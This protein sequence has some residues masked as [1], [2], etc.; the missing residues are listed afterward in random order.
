MKN[1]FRVFLIVFLVATNVF[2]QKTLP[3]KNA[4][5]S[6]D[7]RAKDLVKRM[8]LDEKIGQMTQI[9]SSELNDSKPGDD[10][11][12][13]FRPYLDPAKAEKLVKEYHV[14]SFLV[15]FAVEPA[16]WV[17]FTSELQTIAI[18][19]SRWG[20]P[21]IYGNDNIHGANYVVG[22]TIFPQALGLSCTF[23]TTLAK[24]MGRVTAVE[25]ADLGQP[26]NFAPV[27]DLGRNP[28]WPR[29]YESMGEST[30]LISKMGVAYIKAMQECN[31][32]SPY[33]I[34]ATAKHFIGYGD[35]KSGWDRMPAIISDQEL[36]EY[37]VPP[38]REAIKAGVKTFMINSAEVN[39]VPV[40]ASARLINGLLRK[41]LGFDGVVVTD[42]ADI[43]QLIG[44][45][46][47]AKDER[48][49]T[50]MALLAGIDMSMTATSTSFCRVTKELVESKEVPMS[51]INKS[52]YRILKLKFEMG[53][54][55][56][57]YPRA[58]RF[59][60]IGTAEN[61]ALALE[62]AR[63]SLV[64]LQNDG[65]LPLTTPKNIL[66]VGPT[67]NSKRN[68]CG[69]WTIEW[70]GAGEGLFPK[71]METVFS[72]LTKEYKGSIV[73]SMSNPLR[74][75]T[76]FESKAQNADIIIVAVG[77]PPHAE[78]RGNLEDLALYADQLEMIKAVQATG[79]KSIITI[80]SGRPRI[81]SSVSDKANAIIWAGLPG[82]E[83]AKALAEVMSGKTNPSGKLSFTYPRA[84][85]HITPYNVKVH[86]TY[87]FAWPFGHGLSYTQ[88]EYSNLILSDS[89]IKP[90]QE[91]TAKVTIK[92][93][94]VVDGYETALWYVSDVVRTISPARKELKHFEK[95][96][97]KA[98]E[99]KEF[100]FT[101]N[102]LE[103]L[104]YPNEKGL[105]QLEDGTFV[106]S[107]GE[108]KAN[109][110]LTKTGVVDFKKREGKS[111][112]QEDI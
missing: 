87:T 69:A 46:H 65:V 76:E 24:E 90:D 44:Q 84:G 30:H 112:L 73:D 109:L 41:E 105:I 60:R 29:L 23:N 74:N 3:Y 97:L 103:S 7:K 20:I 4:N 36:Y 68:I 93:K 9:S 34:A 25:V 61:K 98:G 59:N 21:M 8:S 108:L 14:G 85:G 57:P 16:Q 72:A 51:V 64:L 54:F 110:H 27:L 79:K 95:M 58:D 35:S 111:H 10:K 43:L 11:S 66:I 92:N 104:S 53:L 55:E 62:A 32:N 12:R 91:I 88:F 39:G 94:G 2:S 33:K 18:K 22:S 100:S 86:D 107:V 83:G 13:R 78:G 15:G 37:F 71:D 19:N 1:L 67:T 26:W 75:K 81:I 82:Y 106:I 40:H 99:E 101:I 6:A 52:V 28:Y 47:V 17:K 45:H 96:Y 63:Q 31:E 70:G 38:F 5:L 50:K 102:P 42:W 48:E 80:F 49:A 77:E 89:I 56:N